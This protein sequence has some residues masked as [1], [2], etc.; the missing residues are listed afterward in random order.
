MVPAGPVDIVEY[1]RGCCDGYCCRQVR[2]GARGCETAK[3]SESIKATSTRKLG[4][5]SAFE[6]RGSDVFG[7]LESEN[8]KKGQW[9]LSQS[10][11]PKKIKPEG[12][13]TAAEK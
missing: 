4:H 8:G 11:H 10:K 1:T 2:M 13:N 7:K 12:K 3:R 9:V 5:I 6:M